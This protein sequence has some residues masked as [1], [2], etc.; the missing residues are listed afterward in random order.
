VNAHHAAKKISVFESAQDAAA[1]PGSAIEEQ[2]AASHEIGQ[3][4][5]TP[6]FALV[7]AEVAARD[8]GSQRGGLA[9]A[10]AQAFAGD[11]IDAAGSVTDKGDIAARNAWT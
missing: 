2:Q 7:G 3:P 10:Q 9:E 4:G 1:K 8:G 5:E 11:R 6:V